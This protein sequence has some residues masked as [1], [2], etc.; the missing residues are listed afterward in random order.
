M[1]FEIIDAHEISWEWEELRAE[2]G[3]PMFCGSV[4]E[5]GINRENWEE[6]GKN[7]ISYREIKKVEFQNEFYGIHIWTFFR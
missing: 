7:I 3:N 6:M 1:A 4:E 5:E 2:D